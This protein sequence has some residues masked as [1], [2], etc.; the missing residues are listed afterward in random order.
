MIGRCINCG[1]GA[2]RERLLQHALCRFTRLPQIA[3]AQMQIVK[4][5]HDEMP[6]DWLRG[7]RGGFGLGISVGVGL[8]RSVGQNRRRFGLLNGKPRYFLQLAFIEELEIFLLQRA[9]GVPLAIANHHRH[10]HQIYAGAEC[11][12]RVMLRYLC[13]GLR[14][15]RGTHHSRTSRNGQYS[16]QYFQESA[17]THDSYYISARR[18]QTASR[19]AVP[20]LP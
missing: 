15:L 1:A 9:D 14:L 7:G 17:G 13:R 4:E 2:R 16:P 11:E 20:C 8:D 10:Q 3:G 5:P 6:G 18:Q 19:T 12:R